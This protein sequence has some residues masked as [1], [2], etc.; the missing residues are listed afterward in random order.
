MICVQTELSSEFV[1]EGDLVVPAARVL[2]IVVVVPIVCSFLR[3]G[4]VGAYGLGE[5]RLSIEGNRCWW[6]LFV[7]LHVFLSHDGDRGLQV[8]Q[9]D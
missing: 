4:N 8:R 2:V 7:F 9:G 5:R 3:A 6:D 1:S